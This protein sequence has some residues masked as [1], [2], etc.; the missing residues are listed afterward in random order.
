MSCEGGVSCSHDLRH[1]QRYQFMGL[2]EGVIVGMPQRQGNSVVCASKKY[3]Q[4]RVNMLVR[5]VLGTMCLA[6]F[7]W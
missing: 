3:G 5:Y 4:R 1:N 7:L 2:D 6:D